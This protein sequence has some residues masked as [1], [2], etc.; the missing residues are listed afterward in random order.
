MPC[1]LGLLALVAPRFVILLVV[2]FSD[3]IGTAYDTWIVPFL[4]FFF[5]PLTTL[6]YA[7]AMHSRGEVAGLHLAGVILA[8]L[9][10]FGL[11]GGAKRAAGDDALS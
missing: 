10:D 5:V 8:A 3:Y 9:V 2:V 6:A 7:W 4:G 1:C 11:L